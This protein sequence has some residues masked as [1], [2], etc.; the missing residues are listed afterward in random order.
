MSDDAK[1]RTRSGFESTAVYYDV[2]RFVQVVATRL[3]ELARL[4]PGEAVLDVATG[5]GHVAL[6]AASAVGERGNVVGLD[7]SPR[8]LEQARHKAAAL[9]LSNVEWHEG[10]GEMPPFADERF[11]AVLCASGIFFM[12][13]QLS[14]LREWS[15][16]LKRGGRVLFTTFGAGSGDLAEMGRKQLATMGV[17]VPPLMSSLL[18][19]PAQSRALLVDAGFVDVE[20]A[21]ERHDYWFANAEEWW[22]NEYSRLAGRDAWASLPAEQIERFK[23]ALVADVAQLATADGVRRVLAVNFASGRKP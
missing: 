5:T 22:D 9:G 12:P 15:R 23:Q 8:M 19:D 10:D 6:A 13:N 16:C 14:A 2:M 17:N 18:L 4:Q 20:V 11:D 1:Q 7:L 21:P 3:L